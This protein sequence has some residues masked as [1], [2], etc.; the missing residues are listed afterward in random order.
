MYKAIPGCGCSSLGY[1]HLR[2]STQ[3]QNV[4]ENTQKQLT[5]IINTSTRKNL[6]AKKLT[7]ISSTQEHAERQVETPT[8]LLVVRSVRSGT[9]TRCTGEVD[10]ERNVN[11]ECLHC[12]GVEE[13]SPTATG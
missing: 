12:S 6:V 7:F 8:W 13:A 4:D 10:S 2:L 9:Q 1:A 5:T 3:K 11:T